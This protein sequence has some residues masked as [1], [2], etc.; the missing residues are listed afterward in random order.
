M[1]LVPALRRQRQTGFFE[2]QP[3]MFYTVGCTQ[4]RQSFIVRLSHGNKT[5]C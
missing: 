3:R 1:P 4:Y 2:F 5:V